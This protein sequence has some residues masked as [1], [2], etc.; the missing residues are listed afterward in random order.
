VTNLNDNALRSREIHGI[1]KQAALRFAMKLTRISPSVG[2]NLMRRWPFPVLGRVYILEKLC[3]SLYDIFF[4]F[5]SV[6][7]EELG[8]HS[9]LLHDYHSGLV[10]GVLK[11]NGW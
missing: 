5:T 9:K 2:D 7:V 3:P 1:E 8:S 10:P 6:A 4:E 11:C